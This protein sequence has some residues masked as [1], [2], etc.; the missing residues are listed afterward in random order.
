MG[1]TAALGPNAWI[2]MAFA[3]TGVI[4]AAVYML[5]MFQRIFMDPLDNPENQGLPDVNGRELA[6][7]RLSH[8]HRL[9]RYF[10]GQLV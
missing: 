7:Y 9:D 5:W 4:L 3:V 8:L 6:I 2:H 10:A 1:A